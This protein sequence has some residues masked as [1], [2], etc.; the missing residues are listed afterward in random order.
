MPAGWDVFDRDPAEVLSGLISEAGEDMS[1]FGA[2]YIGDRCDRQMYVAVPC[3]AGAV[4]SRPAHVLFTDMVASTA[5][6]AATGGAGSGYQLASVFAGGPA[7]L[8]ANWLLHETGTPYSISV[9]IIVA[10]VVTVACVRAL[11][12]R[13]RP[14]IDD[15]AVYSRA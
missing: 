14:N 8:L 3:N 13:S 11:P 4:T 5:H 2:Q 7:L 1:E 15:T 12:D 9:Y 6:A 10:A